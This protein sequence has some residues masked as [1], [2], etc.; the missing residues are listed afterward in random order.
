ML[1]DTEGRPATR[2]VLVRT[3]C[4]ECKS[5]VSNDRLGDDGKPLRRVR[6]A[7]RAADADTD[8]AASCSQLD[9][10]VMPDG[11]I[12][13]VYE[14][15]VVQHKPVVDS[16]SQMIPVESFVRAAA[17]GK[18]PWPTTQDIWYSERV[19]DMHDDVP[20]WCRPLK[21][22]HDLCRA[23][24]HSQVNAVSSSCSLCFARLLPQWPYAHSHGF[25]QTQRNGCH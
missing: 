18:A 2:P 13:L 5:H 14:E 10:S 11:A 1:E 9:G 19:M 12:N 24:A 3:Y 22:D 25:E 17:D 8:A 6:I 7:A 4:T 20:K 15:V 21:P 16:K 23:C